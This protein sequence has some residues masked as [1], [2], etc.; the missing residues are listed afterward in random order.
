M[1][2]DV[3][4]LPISLQTFWIVTG[5]TGAVLLSAL[6]FW[7]LKSMERD[8]RPPL[9]EDLPARGQGITVFLG[10]LWI[11]LF[12][13]T[14][15]A[16]YLGVWEAIHPKDASSQPNLGL[17]ALLAA[18]LGSPFVIWGTW[19]K[20]QTVRY[21]KEGHITDRINKAVEQLGA[22]KTVKK[23]LVNSAGKRVYEKNAKGEIDYSRPVTVEESVPSIEVRIG[24]ILSLERI[25]QDSTTHDKGRDHVRVMEILCSYVRENAPASTAENSLRQDWNRESAAWDDD[26]RRFD[27]WFCTQYGINPM[28]L[29]EAICV[30][31]IHGWAERLPRPREDIQMA[32]RVIGRRTADQRKV[33]AAWPKPPSDDTVWPFDQPYPRL[34]ERPG[35]A[36]PTASEFVNLNKRRKSW[37]VQIQAYHGY[38]IGLQGANLQGADLSPKRRDKS[39]AVFC[40]A[41]FNDT[42]MEGAN[43]SGARFQGANFSKA[44]LAGADLEG[45]QA[46]CAHLIDVQ[47]EGASLGWARMEETYL[48]CAQMEGSDLVGAILEGAN[49]FDAEMKGVSLQQAKVTWAAVKGID[50]RKLTILPS[51]IPTLFGDATVSLPKGAKAPAHWPLWKLD[52]F[53]E[54]GFDSEWDKWRDDPKGYKPPP[55]PQSD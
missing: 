20:Y 28:D 1:T 39:D 40:G 11:G 4:T 47:L 51:Q 14:I 13:L 29:D 31:R 44:W 26:P 43:L 19:L 35:T 52:V 41:L 17:G 48:A 50:L 3:T 27:E 5:L 34:S 33:E 46:E 21:Q 22:E 42:R 38:Q 30:K 23:P 36:A 37:K 16:A 49:L 12:G 53:G 18:L 24:A 2:P 8:H 15:V 10:L 9:W 7:T 55:P 32:L 45:V 6:V 25:A 54:P